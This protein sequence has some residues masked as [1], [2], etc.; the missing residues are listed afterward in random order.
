MECNTGNKKGM[1]AEK[2]IVGLASYG[3][4]WTLTDPSNSNIG[5][6]TSG[7]SNPTSIQAEGTAAYYEVNN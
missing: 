5:A 1:P 3:T 2:I 6:P 7:P 4:G